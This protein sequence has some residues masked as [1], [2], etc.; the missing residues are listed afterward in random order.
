VPSG[1]DVDK[2]APAFRGP[3]NPVARVTIQGLDAP[4]VSVILPVRD[5]AWC[6]SRAIESVLAQTYRNLELIVV[7]D[8]STDETPE[9][10]AA[11]GAAVR[12]LELP[13][14]G[15]YAARNAGVRAAN[16]QLIAFIDSDDAW[17]PEKL[18]LQVPRMR[19]PEVGL[20]FGDARHVTREFLPLGK[21]CFRVAPPRRGR[22]ADAF[23][24]SNFVPTTTVLVRRIVLEEIGGFVESQAMSAD[25]LAW[26]RIALRHELDYV[27]EPVADYT[28]HHDRLSSDLGLTLTARM[29][30][31]AAELSRTTDPAVRSLLRRLLFNLALRFSFAMLRGKARPTRAAFRLLWRAL[32]AAGGV[33]TARWSAALFLHEFRTRRRPLL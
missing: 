13:A 26:F 18:S 15:V 9:V 24:W 22:A 14:R 12:L 6:V 2:V 11:F 5:R 21:S 19:R 32:R 20:V 10:V 4:L 30:I 3:R 27:D 23:V 31:F 7:D 33:E 17:Y 29:E 8:G 25:L 16:G 28:V 1:L